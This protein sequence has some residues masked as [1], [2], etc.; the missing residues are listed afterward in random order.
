MYSQFN[1]VYTLTYNFFTNHFNI[2]FTSTSRSTKCPHLL[3]FCDWKV[4]FIAPLSDECYT[5]RPSYAPLLDYL[6]NILPYIFWKYYDN[7]QCFTSLRGKLEAILPCH[8]NCLCQSHRRNI[9]DH[10]SFLSLVLGHSDICQF[11]TFIFSNTCKKFAG[12]YTTDW[13]LVS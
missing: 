13:F 4:V 9:K 1:L 3:N 8:V 7:C 2:S 12:K 5:S 6:N 10:I 11:A